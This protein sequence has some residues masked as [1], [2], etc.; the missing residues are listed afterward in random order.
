MNWN[1]HDFL[2]RVHAAI[3]QH[4]TIGIFNRSH[5]EDVVVVR[6]RKIIKKDV[7]KQRFEQIN[8]F[9]NLLSN[10]GLT[11]LKIFL[12]IS[13]S[14]QRQRLEDRMQDPKNSGK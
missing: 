6:V 10:G 1:A 12:H 4:G 2:W 3:P 7:W 5:Y 8:A 13:R 14:E 9:E 11:F